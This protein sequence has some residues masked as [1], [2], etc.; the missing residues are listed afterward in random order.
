[1]KKILHIALNGPYTEGFAY[2]DNLLPKYH[3]R[4]GYD[5]TILAPAWRH[6]KNG[7]LEH[8]SAGCS[9]DG[10]VLLVRMETANEKGL[11]DRLKVYPGLLAELEKRQPDIIFLHGCQFRDAKTVVCYIKGCNVRP[12]LYVDNHA[13]YS[14]SATNFV[15]RYILHRVV[16]RYYAKLLEPYTERFW[17]V[18]PARVDFL[19]E[20][21]GL[22][23][24]KCSLLIMGGDDDEV[25]RA[26][27]DVK[28]A[29][30]KKKFN[31]VDGDFVVV[32]GG[33]IDEAKRQVLAL[34]DAVAEMNDHVKLL[35]FG[36][37][38]PSL[39]EEFGRRLACK[40]ITHVPW[41]NTSDS[42]DYFAVANLV[43]FPGRHSVYWEQ[44]VAMEKPLLI[45]Y[46]DGATHVDCGGN[47]AFT[48]GDDSESLKAD[49]ERIKSPDVLCDMNEVAKISKNHFLYSDIARMSIGLETDRA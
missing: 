26:T 14:N 11:D 35:V 33:K 41:A 7:A 27:D 10:D 22:P 17:G 42:Y 12:T 39:R 30:T 45:K 15:S 21:Y 13:D 44:A 43:V 36:P 2:Q 32:T 46:W 38:A 37:V 8:V 40:R 19:V 34:M 16:W 3:A 20:N 1:M 47:V 23:K 48:S 5:V 29:E 31:F 28:V 4:L 6:D 25:R 49:I 18:L 9:C 24:E